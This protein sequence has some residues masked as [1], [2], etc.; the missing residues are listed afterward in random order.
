MAFDESRGALVLV[1][2]SSPADAVLVR[3]AAGWAPLGVPGAPS[4][5]YLPGVAY[6]R[7]RGV[8]VVFG[9]GDA[10]TDALLADT[11]ELDA[12]SWRRRDAP[13]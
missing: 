3:Q 12:T 7:A 13:P 10:I 5:R 9:G 4:A 1:G 11:W 6:D 2:G 8:L